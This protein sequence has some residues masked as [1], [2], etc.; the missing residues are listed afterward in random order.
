M[1]QSIIEY[2]EARCL[3]AS[4]LDLAFGEIGAARHALGR[5]V[6]V[7]PLPLGRFLAF[8]ES[9]GV[10]GATGEPIVGRV[11]VLR[12]NGTL[13]TAFGGTGTRRLGK[14]GVTAAAVQADGKILLA[15]RS[16]GEDRVAIA[17]LNPDGSY[18]TTFGTRGVH[19]GADLGDSPSVTVGAITIVPGGKI[20]LV[21]Q[22]NKPDGSNVQIDLFRYHANGKPDST[23]GTAG[24]MLL[25]DNAVMTRAKAMFDGRTIVAGQPNP[26]SGS[27]KSFVLRVLGDGAIDNSFYS[28]AL[29][30]RAGSWPVVDI[31]QQTDN[32]IILAAGTMVARLDTSGRLDAGFSDDG[33]VELTH[34]EFANSVHATAVQADGKIVATS[35]V[36]GS[37]VYEHDGFYRFN[38]DGT[39]DASFGLDGH[40]T[41]PGDPRGRW[42]TLQPTADGNLL[43]A[44]QYAIPN[45]N[46]QQL[47]DSPDVQTID[48]TLYVRGGEG[49]DLV[50]LALQSDPAGDL[51]TLTFNQVRTSF[52][53]A[54]ARRV[55]IFTGRGN[56]AIQI[57]AALDIPA[58][59]NAGA[60][61]DTITTAGGADTIQSGPGSDVIASGDGDDTL[62][63]GSTGSGS[64]DAGAGADLLLNVRAV[65][66]DAG[67]G[68]DILRSSHADTVRGGGG[69][70]QMEQ[71][72]GAVF[73]DGGND[74]IIGS[75]NADG[76][77]GNDIISTLF[78]PPPNDGTV[79]EDDPFITLRGG[80]G[81]DLLS[82]SGRNFELRGD[83]GAD[84]IRVN[85]FDIPGDPDL[86]FD[87]SVT[88]RSRA[89]GGDGNDT[90]HGGAGNNTLEGNAG[91]DRI[92]LPFGYAS[93][94]GG[95][96]RIITRGSFGSTASGGDANDHLTALE[97]G[98]LL[99]GN[100][101]DVLTGARLLIGG[102]GDDIIFSR[103][104]RTDTL[105]GGAGN[106][107]ATAD[108]DDVLTSIELEL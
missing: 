73:G 45:W 36:A 21:V 51:V 76:G 27:G 40:I 42:T 98:T 35:Y 26:S 9:G 12:P 101:D 3:L 17:R 75:G 20:Q 38:T 30:D 50:T 63:G 94:G 59:I 34:D 104:G 49:D 74:T 108:E 81:N 85:A 41:E 62:T 84:L 25:M 103:N 14:F 57:D 5:L 87:D 48:G 67:E 16:P 46:I 68:H 90:I 22:S 92:Y 83:G 31:D 8:G 96:D 97:G 11:A 1:P 55:V 24:R 4:Q 33:I 37:G 47:D 65:S 70:D 60:G 10:F 54:Q 58:G 32:K 91:N 100:G 105:D 79:S 107:T 52:A 7:M 23:F 29:S 18:D 28:R 61:D 56:D 86:S 88:G 2:L 13:D 66:I 102:A 78:P 39:P 93:G 82:A 99:G 43:T 89:F 80:D 69:D 6:D 72:G 15:G 64:F 53:L 77:A 106:D 44:G 19:V 71:V 95:S